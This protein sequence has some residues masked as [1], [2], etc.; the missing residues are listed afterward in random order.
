[1]P[2]GDPLRLEIKEDRIY[3]ERYSEP[4]ALTPTAIPINPDLPQ[5]DEKGLVE[6]AAKVLKPLLI[7]R[8]DL[9]DLV[10]E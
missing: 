1:M 5:I 3:L 6:E 7:K 2:P 8:S 4:C 9:E 10:A